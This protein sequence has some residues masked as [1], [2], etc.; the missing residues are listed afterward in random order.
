M[1]ITTLFRI[2][3][4]T[5]PI[6][7]AAVQILSEDGHLLLDNEIGRYLP[8]FKNFRD[9]G[10]T[11]RHLLNHTSGLR[12]PGLFLEPLMKKSPQYPEAPTLQLEVS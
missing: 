11:I 3:S 7:A 12:I 2:A 10:M 8:A 5:K 4:N 1:E 6:L 9:R